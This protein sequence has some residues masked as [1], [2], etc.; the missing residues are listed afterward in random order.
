MFEDKYAKFFI[1]WSEV[2][3]LKKLDNDLVLELIC[4]FEII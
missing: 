4:L 3:V 1:G 2:N